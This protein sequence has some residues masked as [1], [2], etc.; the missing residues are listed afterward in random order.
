MGREETALVIKCANDKSI[1]LTQSLLE[2]L[3]IID[4]GMTTYNAYKSKFVKSFNVV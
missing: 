1:R 2:R 4:D 3:L